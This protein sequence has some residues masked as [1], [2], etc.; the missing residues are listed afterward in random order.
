M[1]RE[2]LQLELNIHA[3]WCGG[4]QYHTYPYEAQIPVRIDGDYKK[5][6]FSCDEDVWYVIDLLIEETKEQNEK[7]K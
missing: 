4:C 2:R 5:R 6:I 7:G 3:E 1:G